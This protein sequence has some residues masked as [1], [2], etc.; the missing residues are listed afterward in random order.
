MSKLL[1]DEGSALFGQIDAQR[2]E[3]VIMAGLLSAMSKPWVD[4]SAPLD[5]RSMDS[6]VSM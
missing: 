1:W 5:L 4:A 3:K 2:H 6:I